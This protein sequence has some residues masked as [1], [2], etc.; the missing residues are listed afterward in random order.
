[1]ARTLTKRE[2]EWIK[3]IQFLEKRA[4]EEDLIWCKLVRVAD[5]MVAYGESR[6]S[7]NVTAVHRIASAYLV[8]SVL[9][10]NEAAKIDAV[11][12]GGDILNYG[13]VMPEDT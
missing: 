4:S 13:E 6:N 3:R 9:H 11:H 2:E 7:D 10:Y 1:M 8:K 12:F 5:R